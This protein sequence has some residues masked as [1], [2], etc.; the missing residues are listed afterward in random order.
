MRIYTPKSERALV[1]G[2][3]LVESYL[4][5]ANFPA[6]VSATR[7]ND[8]SAIL[9]D[10]A[11]GATIEVESGAMHYLTGRYLDSVRNAT[12]WLA[13]ARYDCLHDLREQLAQASA[14]IAS[15]SGNALQAIEEQIA[16]YMRK[17]ALIE[18]NVA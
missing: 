6:I 18:S 7:C 13:S 2:I 15:E 9:I 1:G 10:L 17:I 5:A 8:T 3:D 14:N 12:V 11:N 16:R 4:K